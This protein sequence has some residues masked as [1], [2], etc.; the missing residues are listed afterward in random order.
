L[1]ISQKA[2]VPLASNAEGFS[3]SGQPGT[4][5]RGLFFGPS[6]PRQRWG[7]DETSVY[8]TVGNYAPPGMVVRQNDG[9]FVAAS[10]DRMRMRSDL[11]ALQRGLAASGVNLSAG[12]SKW[13]I[14][15]GNDPHQRVLKT[16]DLT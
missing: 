5:P 12:F 1:S 9:L 16:I 3:A 6:G 10:A 2:T 15:L 11:F 14:V 7:V 13:Q 8:D 4:R